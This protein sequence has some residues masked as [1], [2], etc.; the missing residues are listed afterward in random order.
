MP[1]RRRIGTI[2]LIFFLGVILG[3]VLGE[4]IGLILP[5]D[6]VIRELFTTGKEFVVGPVHIDL[7]ILTFTIGFSLKVNLISVLGII[8]VAFLLRLY[9]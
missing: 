5:Q 4:I 9:Y 6:N 8:A 2:A 3:S 1:S 7:I